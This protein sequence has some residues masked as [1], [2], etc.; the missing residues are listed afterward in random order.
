MNG[1]D[2][3]VSRITLDIQ[4]EAEIK[5]WKAAKTYKKACN[6]IR[7]C[8]LPFSRPQELI[9]LANVGPTMVKMLE[10]R[11]KE[12][13][14][15]LGVELPARGSA[16]GTGE[17]D[18]ESEGGS[19]SSDRVFEA[20][21]GEQSFLSF[22][23]G[24]RPDRL[25]DTL[26]SAGS[27]KNAVHGSTIRTKRKQSLERFLPSPGSEDEEVAPPPTKKKRVTAP[28]LYVPKARS[29]GYAILLALLSNLPDHYQHTLA[30]A[31]SHL[32]VDQVT[33]FED[34]QEDELIIA[35]QSAQLTKQEIIN[36]GR[37]HSDTDFEKSEKGGHYTAWS[38]MKTLIGKALISTRGNPAR[39]WLTK[40][41]WTSGLAVR[42][43]AGTLS[44][45]VT[46]RAVQGTGDTVRPDP[47]PALNRTASWERDPLAHPITPIH[48]NRD[49]GR[50]GDLDPMNPSSLRFSYISQ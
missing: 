43:A 5:Q 3:C 18:G 44:Q 32:S 46:S 15:R 38:S 4:E 7:S 41:G 19:E 11:Q 20:R 36:A 31:P 10:Q 48:L 30:P 34:N 49:G 28:K 16:G 8:P 45:A 17:T 22:N 6:S 1:I 2:G 47:I 23:S 33:E 40:E 29:G 21:A 37:S 24:L 35:L 9:T 42:K 12:Y 14:Q 27:S 13:Y 25:L 26:L 39:Y 50:S